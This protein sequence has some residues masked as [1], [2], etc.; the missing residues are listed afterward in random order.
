[1]GSQ[2]RIEKRYGVLK[3]VLHENSYD[4]QFVAAENGEVLDSGNDTTLKTFA[5]TGTTD[6]TTPARRLDHHDRSPA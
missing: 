5:G 6:T 1:M 4:W 2:T 3:L